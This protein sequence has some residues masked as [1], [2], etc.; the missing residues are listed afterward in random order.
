MIEVCLTQLCPGAAKY[1]IWNDY[2]KEELR[3]KTHS[4]NGCQKS[5]SLCT[6]VGYESALPFFV[7]FP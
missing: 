2:Q 3:P 4:Q 6:E 5:L 7:F 1:S